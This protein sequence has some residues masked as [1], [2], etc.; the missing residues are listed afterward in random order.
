ML[1][2]FASPLSLPCEL[3]FFGEADFEKDQQQTSPQSCRDEDDR[4][5]F[6]HHSAEQGG[7]HTAREDERGG[8][9]KRQDA[10]TRGHSSNVSESDDRNRTGAVAVSA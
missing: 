9:P 2:A 10:G 3:S 5:D 6:A 1:I 7:A 8:Q 4:E